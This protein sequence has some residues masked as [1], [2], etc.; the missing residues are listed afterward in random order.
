MT[1]R[2][3]RKRTWMKGCECLRRTTDWPRDGHLLLTT[4]KAIVVAVD[5]RWRDKSS[6]GH[7]PLRFS[8]SSSLSFFLRASVSFSLSLR[9][10]VC[11]SLCMSLSVSV[12]FSLHLYVSL[13]L[14]VSLSLSL[15]VSLC[16]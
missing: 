13:C 4:R 14:C 6:D 12:C 2:E 1:K 16:L 9:V 3:R 15:D 8:L 7:I 5:T 10:F 11:L